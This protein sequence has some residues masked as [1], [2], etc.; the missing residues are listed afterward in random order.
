MT[1][2]AFKILQAF[3]PVFGLSTTKKLINVTKTNQLDYISAGIRT[4]AAFMIL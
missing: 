1:A 2:T 4:K 3:T